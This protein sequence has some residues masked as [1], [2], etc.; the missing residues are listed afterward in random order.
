MLT[1][2]IFCAALLYSTV[3]HGGASGYL[4]AMALFNVAPGVMKPT[5]LVLNLFVAGVGTYRY[6]R[7]GCFDWKIFWP[8][9]AASIPL[10][11]VGGML[12]LPAVVYRSLLG[13][14]LL[15]AAFRLGV[16][17][18]A[19]TPASL[20]PVPL[21][22]ALGLGGVI[23]MLS[24]LTGVG[25]GIFLSP[26]LLLLGWAD[27]RR[28]AGISAAFILVNSASGL[29]GHAH[30]IEAL[31]HDMLWWVPAAFL[32]GIA[33]AEL[34][35]RRLSPM[36]MRRLLAAVLVIAGLKLLLTR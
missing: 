12:H 4:A 29:L 15:F 18:A 8:F 10:A 21:P 19:H 32:G 20:K 2:L 22:A 30:T 26:L 33:G 6:V 1:F 3:G 28:T 36:W 9:A 27:V 7:A 17:Q 25:G 5:A 24:G 31:P 35:T 16:N 34:G 13:V 23:G 11:F 14:V